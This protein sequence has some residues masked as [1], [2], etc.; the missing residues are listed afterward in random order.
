MLLF[1]F[2]N[3]IFG[4]LKISNIS[5]MSKKSTLLFILL[6]SINLF[7]KAQTGPIE[8]PS[9]Y[10]SEEKIAQQLEKSR[11]NGI[12]EWEVQKQ[13]AYLHAQLKKQNEDISNGTFNNNIS[14]QR[15]IQPNQIM[16]GPCANPGFETNTTAG[17]T[18]NQASSNGATLP[19]PTCFT[20]VA[21]GV[22]ELT[23]VG[24]NSNT[25]NNAGNNTGGDASTSCLCGACNEP[26]TGGLDYYGGFSVVAPPPLGGAH[27]LLLNNANC[28]YLMQRANY[29]FVVTAASASFTFLYAAVLQDGGHTPTQS[30]YF[31]VTTTDLTTGALVP[32]AQYSA[33]AS[34]GNLAGWTASAHDATVYYRNWTT[35][36]LD[37][38][39]IVGN[40]VSIDF[41][42]SDCNAGGHF[43]YAYID[44]S[45]NPLQITNTVPLCPGQNAVLAGPP[46]MATYA[47][48]PGGATTQNLTT[49]TV[50]NYTL[51]TTSS[52]GCPSPTLYY[53]LT[54]HPD[55]VPSFTT[56]NPPC[57]GALTFTDGSTIAN[58]D[59]IG[60]W[61]WNFG[62]GSASVS[63]TTGAAQNHSYATPGNYVVTLTD[64]SNNGCVATYTATVNAG[65]GGPNPIF[66]TNAPQCLA[67][68]SVAFTNSSTATG[69]VVIT[70]YSWDFGDGSPI[71]NST[72]VTPN[73]PNHTYTATGT[74]VVTLSVNVT[75]CNATT[76]Q[77]VVINPAP[78]ASFTVPSVCVGNPSVFTST[79]TSGTTYSWTF[80]D[81][82]G[83]S[84]VA[85]PTYT[86]TS[87]AGSPYAVSL[88]V[89]A[90]G[91]CSVTATG[92]AI[93]SP[94]PTATFTVAPVCQGTPSIFDATGSTPAVGGTYIW[95]FGG[96]APNTDVVTVQ[97]DNHTYSTFGTFPVTL[98]VVVGTCS[99]TATGNAVVNTFP[100]LGFT[101]NS[102]CDGFPVNFANTTTNPAAITTWH[103]DF[104]DG[105]TSN[106][107]SPVY[108]YTAPVGFSASN[109]YPVVLTATASTGCSGSFSTTVNVHNNPFAY[110]NAFEA[111]LGTPSDFIDSSFVQNPP[112]LN[113]QIVS[114]QWSFGD[115]QTATYN[116]ATLP[117]TIKHTYAVCNP[118]NITLT[119][120]TN[121]NCTNVN[122]LTGDTVFC[123]PSVVASPD[124]SVCPGAPTP[125]QT[126]TTTCANGGTPFTVWAQFSNNTGAPA[127]Y[128]YNPAA[129]NF[130]VVPSYNAITP[131]LNCTVIKDTV[132]GQ[133]YS[134][135]GC[136]GNETFYIANVFP[137]PTVTPTSN[138]AVCA[139]T[140]VPSINFSGCPAPGE[141][142]TWTAT[143]QVG[144]NIGLVSPGAGNIVSFTGINAANAAAITEVDVTPLA[145]GCIGTPTS[146]SITVNPIPI[147]T[148]VGSTVCPGDNIPSPNI[149]T[150]PANPAAGV[151]FAWTVTNNTN[152][153]MPASGTGTP[154]PYIAPANTTLTNQIGVI[155]Y[156]PTLGTCVGLPTTD[157]INIKPTPYLQH[158]PNQYWCPGDM[159]NPIIFAT[160]PPSL[161]SVYN[162]NFNVGGIPE[163]GTL[164]ILPSFG[165][166]SNA[167]LTTV[168]T[169]VHVKPSLNGCIGPDSTFTIF[170]YP[171]PQ[172]NFTSNIVC[173]GPTGTTFSNASMPNSG[174]NAVS[175][176]NWNFGDGGTSVLT[177][178]T[179]NFLTAGTQTVSLIVSTNPSPPISNGQ[180]GCLDT[181]I[182]NP[183]VNPNPVVSFNGDSVGCPPFTTTLHDHSTVML[184]GVTFGSIVS[185]NWVLGN[186][187][188][189]IA[190]N[191]STTYQNPSPNTI[192]PYNVS[193]TVVTDKGCS[194]TKTVSQYIKV[195][196][197]PIAGFSWG[198]TD[199]DI[200]NPTIYFTNQSQGASEYTVT[201]P[202][203]FGN[204]GIE[205][206]LGDNYAPNDSVNH[207]YSNGSFSHSYSNN[208]LQ[209][210]SNDTA[211]YN[212]KQWVINKYGCKD[213]ITKI[214]DIQPIFTFYIPNAF[215]PNGDGKNEGFKGEG[216]G[217]DNNTYN[218][219]VFD[220]WGMMIY[221]TTDINKAWD[222]HMRGNEGAPLL[223]EDV[224][225]WKVKFDDF[226]GKQHEYHGT[227][228]LVK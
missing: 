156:V 166:T 38:S 85:N 185:W 140:A 211:F 77:T 44:A 168:S 74:Y 70:G 115:G 42:V 189:S 111:C 32:C 48:A 120:T 31:M 165:P 119:V 190:Q 127:T 65:G 147:M 40:T 203:L 109:C 212:V 208:Y 47:W 93:V 224:Y 100:T 39:G 183:F 81:G 9:G 146:F 37:F 110:F 128:S 222:G 214:V 62:D 124:F 18:F 87:V 12:Q 10:L 138:I 46:G 210:Q 108:T 99:A 8:Y 155:T 69:A 133:S 196:P 163:T 200:D 71:V 221:Y 75:G 164:S 158:V 6:I 36:T 102:P 136:P 169:L 58:P 132:F 15:F 114:W 182:K 86:Y 112:C 33:T 61:V 1:R 193:L 187:T 205:Y 95:S 57:S 72:T 55:P 151:T 89:T 148:A 172:A 143:P 73:P 144:G 19:C 68:N 225:V 104:G 226:T 216:I 92:S 206:Y 117:D 218:M 67:G 170:V 176:W 139:N 22:Y 162:W 49:G 50:G 204:Y 178:P 217:I 84:T 20:G 157:T 192:Q 28:G 3:C 134:G 26:Y 220:R 45:C 97:T 125:T 105:D 195:Y 34:S 141:T 107:Q 219:W 174:A 171:K 106:V 135:V 154:A 35:V 184:N 201:T 91:G 30:P 161:N 43:G 98:V 16:V 159:T 173:L 66:T 207:I 142:F 59:V 129:L 137:T 116:T 152:I 17:W 202:P 83:T 121:N 52:T 53:N 63:A 7:I 122:T 130:D 145:N 113:D 123:I 160:L 2:K 5:I 103:W 153:G 181:I 51:N 101:A 149:T 180:T 90:A 78:T 177:N 191:P 186:G 27:S 4:I 64:T 14:Q 13:N 21:G 179:H 56:S 198:P 25:N 24:A 227:V 76:T 96:A 79:I 228:T 213:S 80:G 126:F 41:D 54:M 94:V 167:G 60:H 150:I 209:I 194:A 11:K 118:Y 199:A 197:R 88:T 188:N 175:S 23:S 82:V 29:S 223:Q 131:N 215:T